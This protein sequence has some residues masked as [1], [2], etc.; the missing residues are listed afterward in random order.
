MRACAVCPGLSSPVFGSSARTNIVC[1]A[2]SARLRYQHDLARRGIA[3][4]FHVCT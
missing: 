4:D 3:I 1:V 2:E